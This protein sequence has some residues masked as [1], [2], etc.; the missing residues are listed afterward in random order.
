MTMGSVEH[1]GSLW[2]GIHRQDLC[3]LPEK[4]HMIID[5]FANFTASTPWI[6]NTATTGAALGGTE[7]GGTLHLD[8]QSTTANQGAQLQYDHTS[9]LPA[10]TDGHLIV[11][12]ASLRIVDLVTAAQVFVG[13]SE[14]NSAIFSGGANQ[15]ANHV[16]F[17]MSTTSQTANPG[18]LQFVGEKASARATAANVHTLVEDTYVKLG[19]RI[20]EAKKVHCY[21]NR[22]RVGST[23]LT[24]N[25]PIVALTPSFACL[26]NGGADPIMKIDW[27]QCA[28][29]VAA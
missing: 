24:A 11:F 15:T 2:G 13:L 16:G 23:I 20:E 14:I 12:E 7:T 19:F 18:R 29:R 3:V 4:G 5:H 28:Q 8:S 21:V 27:V 6:F 22:Q 9:F 26:S 25:I 1:A 10:S 17:E